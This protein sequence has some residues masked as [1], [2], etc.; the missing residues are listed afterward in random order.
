MLGHHDHQ[1]LT[2]ADQRH[3]AA[4]GGQYLCEVRQ[5]KAQRLVRE[6]L[7][8]RPVPMANCLVGHHD[9]EPRHCHL[10]CSRTDSPDMEVAQEL[11]EGRSKRAATKLSPTVRQR[12]QSASPFSGGSISFNAPICFCG[13]MPYWVFAACFDALYLTLGAE[14]AAQCTYYHAKYLTFCNF[15]VIISTIALKQFCGSNLWLK[16]HWVLLSVSLVSWR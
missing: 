13:N 16:C 11:K 1:Q 5:R 7:L 14:K 4:L 8:Q 10:A 2:V 15:Y 9:G 3:S 6:E 12:V